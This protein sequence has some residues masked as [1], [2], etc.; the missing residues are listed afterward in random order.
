M[1]AAI[2]MM[3]LRDPAYGVEDAL[4]FEVDGS[5]QRG[6]VRLWD[7]SRSRLGFGRGAFGLE[8]F[9]WLR[10]RGFGD[11]AFGLGGFGVG[12]DYAVVTTATRFAAGDYAVR[13]R[14]VDDLGHRGAWSAAVTIAHRPPPPPPHNLRVSEGTLR[15][16]HATA[17]VP[18]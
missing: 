16:D 11:S 10:P 7:G 4:E 17:P 3:V 13:V 9:G 5:V 15:W 18:A 14:G 6:L 1:T 2:G 8:P 12:A